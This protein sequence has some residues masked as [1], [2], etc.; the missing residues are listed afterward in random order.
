LRIGAKVRNVC[1]DRVKF[2]LESQR[3]AKEGAMEVKWRQILLAGKRHWYAV[4]ARVHSL[5]RWL[6]EHRRN[7]FHPRHQSFELRLHLENDCGAA[8]SGTGRI[9]GK[10]D[11]V[12]ESLLGVEQD[13]LARKGFFAQ[14]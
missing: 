3:Q 8:R 5:R 13:G 7:P 6:A 14:P 11:R 10:L 4:N 12:A 1:W 2:G 9:A